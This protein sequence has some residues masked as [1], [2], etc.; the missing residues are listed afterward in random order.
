M[1]IIIGMI[2]TVMYA[3]PKMQTL[4]G[5]QPTKRKKP[6]GAMDKVHVA[7]KIGGMVNRVV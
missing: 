6:T 7:I 4:S 2:N 5:I 1:V 3:V